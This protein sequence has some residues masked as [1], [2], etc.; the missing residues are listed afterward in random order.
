MGGLSWLLFIHSRCF[1]EGLLFRSRNYSSIILLAAL[2]C[3]LTPRPRQ[4][5]IPFS[6][7]VFFFF[8]WTQEELPQS[9]VPKTK[10]YALFWT[11]R[12]CNAALRYISSEQV[13]SECFLDHQVFSKSLSLCNNWCTAVIGP[14]LGLWQIAKKMKPE[15]GA[16]LWR[17]YVTSLGMS[18]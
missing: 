8:F 18:T 13:P 9:P 5:L 1:R 17:W 14:G 2:S 6:F 16:L 12:N 3:G 10:G 15:A 4:Y 7:F 11:K